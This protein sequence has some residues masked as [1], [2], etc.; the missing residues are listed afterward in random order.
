MTPART[1]A[2]TEKDERIAPRDRILAAAG[3]LFY[4]HG[5]RAV[6]VDAI[7][8]AAHTNKMTLYRHFASKDE[9]VAEY[10]RQCAQASDVS[11]DHYA[12]AHPGDA[13]AQ[14][15]AWLAE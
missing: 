1:D 15:R 14:L 3:D 10:L 6:G 11:W 12:A 8:E 7:A 4:R 13:L 9:L 2:S 5:I